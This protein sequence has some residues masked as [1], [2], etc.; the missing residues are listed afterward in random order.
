M[1]RFFKDKNWHQRKQMIQ[2]AFLQTLPVLCGYL[3]LGMAFGVLLQKA[4][5]G[6]GWAFFISLIVYAGSMQFVL[7]SLLTSGVSLLTVAV[8]TLS[9]NSRHIFYGLSFIEKFQSMGKK[10]IYMIA[11]LTDETYSV[12]CGM[13][14]PKELE[15]KENNL[16]FV[17]AL[18][19]HL[20]WI[21]GSML[22]AGIGQVLPFDTR[23][24][25]FAM[26]AL[27]IVIYIEQCMGA[28]DKFPAILGVSFAI[29]SLILF[30]KQNFLLS[31]LVGT[32]SVLLIRSNSKKVVL[33]KE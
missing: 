21:I 1:E 14:I 28:K 20:Y 30:G 25:D 12:L 26:T 27:F 8:M 7:I 11:S 19:N 31:A 33:E 5:Y 22:G 3:F 15:K 6:I 4:G 13:K 29:V 9:I 2:Y 16:F 24:I 17:V 18:L 23:G 32:V 10:G